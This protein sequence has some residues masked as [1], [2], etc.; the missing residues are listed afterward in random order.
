MKCKNC[1]AELERYIIH[2][3][4]GSFCSDECVKEFK[5]KM[6]ESQRRDI[7]VHLVQDH[8]IGRYENF[9]NYLLCDMKL[10]HSKQHE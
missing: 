9:G 1:K 3:K 6:E 7:I 4:F 8:H 10:M 2:T 5:L